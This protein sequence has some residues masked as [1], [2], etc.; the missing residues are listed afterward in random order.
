MSSK[1][2][3]DQ[4]ASLGDQN[5][6]QGKN[7]PKADDFDTRSL[8]D[9]ATFAGGKSPRRDVSLGDQMTFGAG[10][11]E[12][13]YEDDGMEIIDLEA[14][15]KIE[16]VLGKG[17]MGEV[18]L[19]T[20][21]R[22][23]RKVAIKRILGEAARSRTAVSRFLT[24]AQSI[25]ALNHPNIVQ[26]YDYGRAEDGP[27]LIMEFVEGNSL[28]DRCREGALSVEEAV[29]LTC[30][31]CDGLGKAH[32]AGIVHRDIKPAN[33]LMTPDGTP[34]LTDFGLAKAE[35]ADTGMT[36]AGAVL[37]TL[38]FMPPEQRRDAALTDNRSDLWSLAATLYQMVTGKSPKIIKFNDVPKG[39]QDV[40][41]KA[42]E[43]QKEDRFQTA[44]E[45]KQA[46][47][48]SLSSGTEVELELG[49]CPKCGTKNETNRKFCKKCAQ[50]L[51]APCLSCSAKIPMWEEVCGQCGSQQSNLLEQRKQAMAGQRDQAELL[52][53][54]FDFENANRIAQ[55]VAKVSD[56]RLQQ[57]KGWSDKFLQQV[58]STKGEQLTRVS[59]LVS[60]AQ[61]HEQAY[62]YPAA[63]HT[64]EQV[65]EALRRQ[66]LSSLKG[67]TASQ[68]IQSIQK[69]QDEAQRLEK[70]IRQR[71][72]SKQV[73]GLLEKLDLFLKLRPDHAEMLKL[74]QQLQDRDAKLLATRDEAFTNAQK[75]MASEDYEGVLKEIARIDP[76]FITP[77]ITSLKDKA[78]ST[79]DKLR[80][81]RKAISKAL[82]QKQYHGLLT[83]V[84]QLLVLRPNDAAMKSLQTQLIARDEKNAAQIK[85]TVNRAQA[86]ISNCRFEQGAKEL[87]R[88]P[89][90]L[91][92]LEVSDLLQTCEDMSFQRQGAL[93][94]LANGI[95]TETFASAISN[96]NVYRNNISL[97]G[98]TDEE[99]RN[100]LIKC[101]QGLAAQ[102]EAAAAA[103]R[104]KRILRRVTM[105][106]AACLV[107]VLLGGAW[108]W[109]QGKMRAR[110][111]ESHILS[112]RWNDVLQMEPDNIKALL[113]R[114]ESQFGMV[115]P[116]IDIVLA[117]LK[118]AEEIAG[119]TEE[120]RR[121]YNRAYLT[122][123]Q[124]NIKQDK[125]REAEA[126]LALI[127]GMNGS[128][129]TSDSIGL[130]AIRNQIATAYVKEA[131]NFARSDNSSQAANSLAKA[132]QYDNSVSTP[133]TLLAAFASDAVKAFEISDSDDNLKKAT[134]A[135][136]KINQLDS[137][138][139]G[140]RNRLA[141]ALVQRGMRSIGKDLDSAAKD[142]KRAQDMGA[143]Q[144][145]TAGLYIELTKIRANIAVSAFEKNQDEKSQTE[146]LAQ[147][148]AVRS[149]DP[150]S[151]NDLLTRFGEALCQKGISLIKSDP[152]SSAQAYE[153]LSSLGLGAAFPKMV[154]LQSGVTTVLT[155]RIE[156]A[157]EKSDLMAWTS[158]LKTLK[159]INQQAGE[160]VQ[161]DVFAKAT[162]EIV[163]KLPVELLA[164]FPEDTIASFPEITNSIGMKL[165]LV[166]S[167]GV[168]DKG[169]YKPFYMG[170]FE[171]TQ[172]EFQAVMGVNP[173]R[174]KD[175]RNP[176]E[177]VG[178]EAAI[179]FCRKLSQRPE[180]KAAG[181][182]YRLPINTE[183]LWASSFKQ[184]LSTF[185]EFAA[186]AWYKQNSENEPHPV[187]RKSPNKLGLFDVWGNVSE[188]CDQ[189]I[190]GNQNNVG[191]P[192]F[193][194]V[195]GGAGSFPGS[196][197]R[198]GGSF[199]SEKS[200]CFGL[201]RDF[202][203][204]DG[205][206]GFRVVFGG[207]L[208]DIAEIKT[209]SSASSP[210]ASS[211]SNEDQF[212]ID[213]KGSD[214]ITNTIGMQL[215]LIQPGSLTMTEGSDIKE[216][217]ITKAFYIGV[218]EV[219]QEQYEKVMGNNP[220]RFRG[221]NQPV[222]SISW[223]DA[224]EFCQR[225]SAIPNEQ[226]SRSVYRLPTS[227]EWEYACRAGTTTEFSFGDDE[228]KIDDY[229]WHLNNGENRTHPV[230]E[231]KANPWGLFD[232]HGNVT[233]WC[234]DSIS[235]LPGKPFVY[236]MLTAQGERKKV[237][238]G[239][240]R[241]SPM[242]CSSAFSDSQLASES[243]DSIGFRVVLINYK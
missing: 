12:G 15:Y 102:Q 76:Y 50:S 30:Q 13:G 66:T 53:E 118:R 235:D 206:I 189:Q 104:N 231:K 82:E 188:W 155:E 122:R 239:S 167:F 107:L 125:I 166:P 144:E 243:G 182:V 23:N 114:A 124:A 215:K 174:F 79:A 94:A 190:E 31:L 73:N 58:D 192:G 83:K 199:L 67:I 98:W 129:D 162:P 65:P 99:F 97:Q 130:Q 208:I 202:F 35:S 86:L 207:G 195:P 134:E 89:N 56:L 8:G 234:A 173:S 4:D 218:Y 64:L 150:K 10:G 214:G 34:K 17:G 119:P 39:L 179:E 170:I 63:L 197:V 142:L 149:L 236:K 101:Q 21:T 70:T 217:T 52:L 204:K 7:P 78:S 3:R 100:E 226:K 75:C 158:D 22:L 95:N 221:T 165:K 241:H 193:S 33:V 123:A 115:S 111:L 224:F 1:G 126:D 116:D 84:N 69:K 26:I 40:L 87:S 47:K 141:T 219:T 177:S 171:V 180:E 61:K 183:W 60:E 88:I 11:D 42:L 198:L 168:K 213:P 137:S 77:E 138:V 117:D 135:L 222:E 181:R 159:K 191:I 72:A 90:E 238:F 127:K 225:L 163:Q 41:G 196:F 71:V 227:V 140:L 91:Q 228:A 59:T 178:Y 25:A 157:I 153:M 151:T 55:E 6:F 187:G 210:G 112:E 28:L 186:S 212:S 154:E 216:V 240:F 128:A 164:F 27:F 43:D 48:A 169:I 121:I 132:Q 152:N 223:N 232:M 147:L 105:G 160:K 148:N 120:T 229:A 36:M 133:R 44:K 18:L 109:I 45:F 172:K 220:S 230:G 209:A 81:L 38:D 242:H 203:L 19:A 62:D 113:G 108:I 68:L 175:A 24:E 57:L 74:K 211:I 131:E 20:D 46:L 201:N 106:V 184:D 136:R 145:I 194:S 103:E 29:E 37:G 92:T 139:L 205:T 146:A 80:D 85:E 2:N 51:E 5:T 96:A 233:E 185:S 237:R 93:Q 49:A 156:K 200:E 16:K 110:L 176:V 143:A 9:Q 32:D 161:A 54:K 14:R